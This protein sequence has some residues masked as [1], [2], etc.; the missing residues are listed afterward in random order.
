MFVRRTKRESLCQ[1][2][3]TEFN[4]FLFRRDISFMRT[5]CL[6]H[7]PHSNFSSEYAPNGSGSGSVQR[8]QTASS[9]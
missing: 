2:L 3:D 9:I 1:I 5:L 6:R 7:V 4:I 8:T